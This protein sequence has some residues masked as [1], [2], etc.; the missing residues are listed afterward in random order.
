MREKHQKQLPILEPASD[1]PQA[2][3]L[4]AISDIIDDNP[5][6]REHIIKD[7]NK[8]KIF[9]RKTGARGMSADQILR[10]AII[11]ILFSFTYEELAF[12]ISDSRSLRRFCRIGISDKGFKKI[13][14]QFEY[15]G[16]F[17]RNMGYDPS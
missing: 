9:K 5:T 3:E 14:P 4:E 16:N 12:H 8:G 11:M 13:S 15:Q 1:H 10:A 7:L 6:I 2:L 17:S